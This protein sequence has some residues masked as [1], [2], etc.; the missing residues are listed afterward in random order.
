MLLLQAFFAFA[1][2]LVGVG[3]AALFFLT[4][5]PLFVSLIVDP[6]FSR[7]RKELSLVTYFLGQTLPLTT[8]TML[9]MGT[10]DFFVPLV[11]G[12]HTLTQFKS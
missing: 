2:Q 9:L 3:S 11:R 7:G 4:G 1:L 10:L 6:L 8:G 12:Y 5:L